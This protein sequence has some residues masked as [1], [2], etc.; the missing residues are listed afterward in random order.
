M[1]SIVTEPKQLQDES[2]DF[3]FSKL[4]KYVP[5]FCLNTDRSA[6]DLIGNLK[7]IIEYGLY[8][9][10]GYETLED[11]AQDKL[12]HSAQWCYDIINIYD[13]EQN[14]NITVGE[15]NIKQQIKQQEHGNWSE[16]HDNGDSFRAIARDEGVDDKTVANRVRN[17]PVFDTK[18]SAPKR[19][20]TRQFYMPKDPQQAFIKIREKFGDEFVEQLKQLL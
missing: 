17:K 12:H 16:R 9:R 1:A 4:G 10:L 7:T 11:Y 6:N 8:L 3:I 20:N 19:I 2:D 14:K 13:K 18:N 5:M 15:L